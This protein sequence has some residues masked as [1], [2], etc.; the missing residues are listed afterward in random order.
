MHDATGDRKRSS[1]QTTGGDH[2]G[3]AGLASFG[4]AWLVPAGALTGE[5]TGT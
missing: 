1:A 4:S 2:A 5:R 3:T